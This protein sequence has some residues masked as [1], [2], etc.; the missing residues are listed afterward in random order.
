M[1]IYNGPVGYTIANDTTKV[2]NYPNGGRDLYGENI[3]I[4]NRRCRVDRYT[5]QYRVC[6]RKIHQ[7]SLESLLTH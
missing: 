5:T 3:F 2:F 6:R 7:G 1:A 4:I